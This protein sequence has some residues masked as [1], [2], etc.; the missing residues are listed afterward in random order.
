MNS[1]QAFFLGGGAGEGDIS[2]LIMMVVTQIYTHIEIYRT[3]FPKKKTQVYC[4]LK[5]KIKK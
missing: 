4:N 2:V 1:T 3:V 5:V